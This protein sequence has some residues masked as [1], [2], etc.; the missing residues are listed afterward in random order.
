MRGRLGAI[1]ALR[2]LFGLDGKALRRSGAE[3]R[4]E[5]SANRDARQRA[6]SLASESCPRAAGRIARHRGG[7]GSH[8]HSGDRFQP[9]SRR[10]LAGD[11][12]KGVF[13]KELEDALLAGTIDLAVH[14]MKDVPTEIPGGLAF[15]AIT[16]REDPRDCLI[17]HA[18]A[19]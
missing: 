12:R 5:V 6:R 17:S 9:A 10:Q 14:S 7:I 1:E 16:R 18:G 13:I 3:R 19:A 4:S 2:H 15:P 11:R 8:P